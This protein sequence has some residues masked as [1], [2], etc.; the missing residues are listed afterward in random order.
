[1]DPAQGFVGEEGNRELS[2]GTA[3]AKFLGMLVQL[4]YDGRDGFFVELETGMSDVDVDFAKHG[5][6]L[7]V[8]TG[9]TASRGSKQW[10]CLLPS[11]E[12]I[13]GFWGFFAVW[14]WRVVVRATLARVVLCL[15]VYRNGSAL[16]SGTFVYVFQ[17]L[18]NWFACSG[19]GLGCR[20]SAL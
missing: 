13:D 11:V 7:Q 10:R 5:W 4:P 15:P 12:K 18:H 19:G 8:A 6:V 3:P 1:M 16:E 9:V 17:I 20:N 2:L 14:H